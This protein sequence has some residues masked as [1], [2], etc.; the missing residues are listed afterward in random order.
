MGRPL[1]PP[2]TTCCT[3][4]LMNNGG[5]TKTDYESN[6][7]HRLQREPHWTF[8]DKGHKSPTSFHYKYKRIHAFTD[9]FGRMK[10][11]GESPSEKIRLITERGKK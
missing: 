11:K 4:K 2:H 8:Y 7:H 1:D 10:D 9:H 5:S 6:L 3:T